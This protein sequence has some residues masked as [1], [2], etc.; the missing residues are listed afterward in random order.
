MEA[1]TPHPLG[2]LAPSLV[3]ALAVAL[4]APACAGTCPI[5]ADAVSVTPSTGCRGS[6][7]SGPAGLAGDPLTLVG[8]DVVF[9]MRADLAAI[10]QSTFGPLVERAFGFFMRAEFPREHVEEVLEA[11]AR[12]QVVAIGVSGSGGFV[13]VAQGSFTDRD[14][15][16][17]R[18]EIQG[19]RRQHVIHRRGENVGVV[20]NGRYLILAERD[21]VEAVL[22]RIDGLEDPA[23]Q[24]QPLLNAIQSVGAYHSYFA[25]LG[26]PQGELR[27][28]LQREREMRAIHGD[29]RWAALSVTHGSAGL[30]IV[31]RVHTITEAA[32]AE[33]RDLSQTARVQLVPE[34]MREAPAIGEAAQALMFTVE[35]TDAVLRWSPA[36]EESRRFIQAFSTIFEQQAARRESYDPAMDDGVTV[37]HPQPAVGP[38][39]APP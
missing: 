16:V 28:E 6:G 14:L 15:G 7:E 26:V 30:E 33:V 37:S 4:V 3:L 2:R 27:R 18:A 13:M 12:T 35:G 19:T 20:A 10:R 8:G 5:P 31:G 36:D 11:V 25:M 23:P 22:D 9:L 32:A 29:I 38:A 24:T 17:V 34:L 1:P 39:V 21:S